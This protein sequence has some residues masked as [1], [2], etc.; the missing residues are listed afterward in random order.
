[1]SALA[2]IRRKVA[3]R[4]ARRFW[5][6]VSTFG[7]SRS[8]PLCGWTGLQFLPRT[9]PRKH[10]YDAFC[11]RCGSAERHRLAY[12]ALHRR[13]GE[14]AY[15]LHV[16]PEEIVAKWLR[17][18]SRDYVSGDLD[19]ARAM[20]RLDLTDID[21]PDD[22]FDLLWVS[23]VLEHV[24]DDAAA[25][26]EMYRVTRPGGMAVVQ[27]PIWRDR[28]FE[29][30]SITSGEARERV[31]YQN[32]HVRLYG[33]DLVDRLA[34]AGFE[35]EVVKTHDFD[36]VEIGRYSLEHIATNEIFLCRKR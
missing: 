21:F 3:N 2:R 9:H 13:L 30:P 10:K 1:V 15:T 25:I 20:R 29:D 5:R 11:P 26:R 35:V 8:C 31:F 14:P 18:V 23:H 19:P 4:L 28:T 6:I 17:R 34:A 22:T 32:N 27:V 16:A 33:M 24:P 36:P 12:H 7:S